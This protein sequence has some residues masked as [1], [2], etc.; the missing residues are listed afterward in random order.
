MLPSNWRTT[1]P[2]CPDDLSISEDGI[3]YANALI[4]DIRG[5]IHHH[6]LPLNV[7]DSTVLYLL[8]EKH[9]YYQDRFSKG[10]WAKRVILKGESVGHYAGIYRPRCFAAMNSFTLSVGHKLQELVVDASLFGN[11][12][13]YINVSLNNEDTGINIGCFRVDVKS[14]ELVFH[15]VEF[16]ALRD[17]NLGEELI[18][19]HGDAPFLNDEAR[20]EQINVP[21]AEV[22][23]EV[24]ILSVEP[25]VAN[26]KN[27]PPK[28]RG[29]KAVVAVEPVQKKHKPEGRFVILEG[30]SH[31]RLQNITVKTK[32]YN[33]ELSVFKTNGKW[34]IHATLDIDL[35]V[36]KLKDYSWQIFN[37]T[38][39]KFED[40][41]TCEFNKHM[42][43]NKR[44]VTTEASGSGII[45]PFPRG[46]FG[47][48]RSSPA[49][50]FRFRMVLG[51]DSN[52]Y[53]KYV[54]IVGNNSDVS[55]LKGSKWTNLYMD[56]VKAALEIIEDNGLIPEC[57]KL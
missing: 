24:E 23:S 2:S 22:S 57:Y 27:G 38:T 29:K 10:V 14:G 46:S 15:T 25:E 1:P 43:G 37:Y 42:H 26:A 33:V 47:M 20:V 30:E 40:I 21:V 48:N 11:I 6:G 39:L 49:F 55:N 3:T 9:K 28:T 31:G 45:A 18:R 32:K 13:R 4:Y 17:I 51:N 54:V 5:K 8:N 50:I 16:R 35:N 7:K 12:T 44:T 41:N 19:A 53:S 56:K 52:F 36:E 34:E